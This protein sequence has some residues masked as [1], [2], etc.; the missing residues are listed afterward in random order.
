MASHPRNAR[1]G[2]TLIEIVVAVVVVGILCAAAFIATGPA[3]EVA[4]VTSMTGDLESFAILET[5][6]FQA[7]HLYI[8]PSKIIAAGRVGLSDGVEIDSTGFSR[9]ADRVYLRVRHVESEQRCSVDLS[10]RSRS[11]RNRIVCFGG[12]GRDS[13]EAPVVVDPP[14]PGVPDTLDAGTRPERPDEPML[15]APLVDG[16][17]DRAVAPGERIDGTFVVTNRSAVSRRFRFDAGTSDPNVAA[18]PS[19]PMPQEIAAGAFIEVSVSSIVHEGVPAGRGAALS[20]IAIDA[21][22]A[23]FQGTDA[24]ALTV[25]PVIEDPVVTGGPAIEV[26]PGESGELSWRVCNRSNYARVYDLRVAA[27]TQLTAI[28]VTGAGQLRFEAGVCRGVGGA[29]RLERPSTATTENRAVLSVT[30]QQAAGHAGSAPGIVVTALVLANPDVAGPADT[31]AAPGDA[32]DASWKVTNRS[33]ASRDVV[34][35]MEQA[36]DVTAE[37]RPLRSVVLAE[38]AS[39]VV[40]GR[41]RVSGDSRDGARSEVWLRVE[42]SRASGTAGTHRF[43]ITTI[44]PNTPPVACFEFLPLLPRAGQVVR[45]DGSCSADP[46]GDAFSLR[47]DLG[48]GSAGAG[49]ILDHAFAGSGVFPVTAVAVDQHGLESAPVTQYVNVRPA[50]ARPTARIEFGPYPD[51][52]AQEQIRFDG[53]E[54][55][56]GDSSVSITRWSWD[57]GDLT[58]GV[59]AVAWKTYFADLDAPGYPVC[60]MVEQSDGQTDR[61]CRDLAIR[62]TTH[63]RFTAALVAERRDASIFGATYLNM[64][65]TVDPHY[66]AGSTLVDSAWMVA[67]YRYANF[68]EVETQANFSNGVA[69]TGGTYC[70]ITSPPGAQWTTTEWYSWNPGVHPDKM[71]THGRSP[72]HTDDRSAYTVAVTVFVLDVKGR[73]TQQTA[74]R[75]AWDGGPAGQALVYDYLLP[76]AVELVF[77]PQTD[78]SRAYSVGTAS[79]A[80]GRVVGISGWS[81]EQGQLSGGDTEWQEPTRT[82]HGPAEVLRVENPGVCGYARITLRM[83]DNLGHVGSGTARWSGETAPGCAGGP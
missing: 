58:E 54:S 63:A 73:V 26:V 61:A 17:S 24:F 37:L 25:L 7:R 59:G 60:L 42:D 35:T 65:M 55:L 9:D 79:D 66:S 30:D 20:L 75:S 47:F 36:G 4:A 28:A 14:L 19:D 39:V 15:A 62:T 10:A 33:N 16:P 77:K 78:G 18:D 12:T 81:V 8:E 57:F 2:F 40:Q 22:D 46:D 32:I 23:A 44:R 34:V 49:T 71:C 5:R 83:I 1:L 82:E 56:P 38:G 50:V 74:T 70:G 72:D 64:A 3:R 69:G 53:S 6:E 68:E 31:T 80:D 41:L 45:F 51:P 21:E 43:A 76:P 67:R 27:P 52:L 29:F 48:D 11:A 13:T